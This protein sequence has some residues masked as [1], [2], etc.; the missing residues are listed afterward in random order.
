MTSDKSY[1][2]Y[3][4]VRDINFEIFKEAIF[5]E[6]SSDRSVVYIVNIFYYINIWI[7]QY[8]LFNDLF[9]AITNFRG[10]VDTRKKNAF[11]I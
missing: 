5:Y 8:E 4:E 9:L 11:E 3:L 1:D 7:S 6:I 2:D 10:F